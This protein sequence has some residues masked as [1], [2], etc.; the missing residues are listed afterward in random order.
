MPDNATTIGLLLRHLNGAIDAVAKTWAGVADATQS[1]VE[2]IHHTRKQGAGQQAEYTVDDARG[3][4]ALIGAVRSARVL[5]G[6]EE[7][8]RAGIR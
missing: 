4:V 3:A 5:N 8:E 2:L 7:A 1:A 6:K